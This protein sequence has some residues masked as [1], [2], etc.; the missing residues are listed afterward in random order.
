MA[1]PIIARTLAETAGLRASP[2]GDDSAALA[3]YAGRTGK[4]IF[5]IEREGI[6]LS[7]NNRFI[8]NRDVACLR[9][10]TPKGD[11]ADRTLLLDLD[12]GEQIRLPIDGGDA[13]SF[14]IFPIHAFLRR[15][16]HQARRSV[17]SPLRYG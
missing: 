17:R 12:S 8:A 2:A 11:P 15:R 9:L 16:I 3:I 14:D 6:R 13:T 10:H 5:V 1:D 4:D 7:A